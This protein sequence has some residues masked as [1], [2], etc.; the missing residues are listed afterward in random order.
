MQMKHWYFNGRTCIA[1]FYAIDDLIY[2]VSMRMQFVEVSKNLLEHLWTLENWDSPNAR[3]L[4]YFGLSDYAPISLY[5][6]EIQ[7]E[8][9]LTM[10][11]GTIEDSATSCSPG[12]LFTSIP[13]WLVSTKT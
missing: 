11:Y 3:W 10:L 12:Y 7:Q 9:A 8:E 1:I 6:K 4:D 13:S 5:K 2:E